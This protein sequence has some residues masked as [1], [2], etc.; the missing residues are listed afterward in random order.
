MASE[1][2]VSIFRRKFS[3]NSFIDDEP[4]VRSIHSLLMSYGLAKERCITSFELL[5]KRVL[6]GEGIQAKNLSNRKR[7]RDAD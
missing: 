5:G 3:G 6:A 4:I 1:A 2:T 7:R